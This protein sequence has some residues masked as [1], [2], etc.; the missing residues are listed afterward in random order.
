[1]QHFLKKSPQFKCADAAGMNR[2]ATSDSC[3]CGP[4][5]NV[6]MEEQSAKDPSASVS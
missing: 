6:V 3:E 4:C 2:S 1:M 5:S